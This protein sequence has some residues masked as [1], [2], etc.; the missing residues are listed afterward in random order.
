VTSRKNSIAFLRCIKIC[1]GRERISF[2]HQKE[3]DRN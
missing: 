3:G 1:S 2:S